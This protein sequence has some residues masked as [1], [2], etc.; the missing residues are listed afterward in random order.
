M[1][2]EELLLAI[3][4]IVKAEIAPFESRLTTLEQK[5]DER[6]RETKP[7]WERALKEIM[8]LRQGLKRVE[9]TLSHLTTQLRILNQDMLRLGPIRPA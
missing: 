7:I 5:V 6:L 8:E 4:Q 2:D 1:T 9:D 3:K